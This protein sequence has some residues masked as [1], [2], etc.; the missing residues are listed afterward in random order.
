MVLARHYRFMKLRLDRVLK[1]ELTGLTRQ[2]VFKSLGPVP[3]F[4]PPEKWTAPYSPYRKG[5]PP[6][7]THANTPTIPPAD[8]HTTP[9]VRHP[10]DVPIACPSLDVYGLHV[11]VHLT[12][13]SSPPSL[14]LPAACISR[15]SVCMRASGWLLQ[16]I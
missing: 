16:S 10:N 2:E 1:L 4:T 8:V 11:G 9:L 15:V 7:L 13:H 6:L 5:A 12:Q 3:E 14:C